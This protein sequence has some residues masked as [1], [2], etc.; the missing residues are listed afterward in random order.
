MKYT[1]EIKMDNAAFDV[2]EFELARILKKLASELETEGVLNEK[3]LLDING[4]MV[5]TA[6]RRQG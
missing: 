2:P 1:I 4:N 3:R 6:E 5:G